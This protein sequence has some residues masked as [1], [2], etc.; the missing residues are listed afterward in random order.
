[1][2]NDF[3]EKI[4]KNFKF[5]NFSTE[6][7]EIF[8]STNINGI[9][10]KKDTKEGKRFL[11][12][13][14]EWFNF[15]KVIYLNQTHSNDILVDPKEVID[16][17]GII[18]SK[19]KVAI[20]VFGADCTPIIIHDKHNGIVGAVHSG[21]KG[22]LN[23]ILTEC[24]QKLINSFN[25]KCNDI[26]IFIGP[27]ARRCCYE[28]NY[29]LIDEFNSKELYR[30]HINDGRMLNLTEC[31]KLQLKELGI[32]EENI[33]DIGKCTICNKEF[34]SYRRDKESSGRNFAFV[35]LK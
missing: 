8:F 16:G 29:E 24:I 2:L 31:I 26:E 19:E 9:D 3:K 23:G 6:K 25:S 20:G 33:H 14:P 1:M 18:T 34:H 17:D 4:V 30:G 10:F 11:S 32:K 35:F 13:L 22:T 27:H 12:M 21:W 28:V 15:E 5:Y 7:A